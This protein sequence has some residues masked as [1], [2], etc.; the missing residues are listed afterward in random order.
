[1]SESRKRAG[2]TGLRRLL[3]DSAVAE[4]EALGQSDAVGVEFLKGKNDELEASLIKIDDKALPK[5]GIAS[6]KE[7]EELIGK[8]NS[9]TSFE[10]LAREKS[11]DRASAASGWP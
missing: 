1:M 11:L 7:A 6:E 3:S 10:S 5:L 2:A 8:I 9:G 4:I